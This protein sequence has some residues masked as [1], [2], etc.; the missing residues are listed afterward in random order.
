MEVPI[1][2]PKEIKGRKIPHTPGGVSG[3]C[4]ALHI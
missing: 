3:R 1:S 2:A 4:P